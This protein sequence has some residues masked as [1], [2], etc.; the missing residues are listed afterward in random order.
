MLDHIKTTEGFHYKG[1]LIS[2]E[3]EYYKCQEC[4]GEFEDPNN[5]NDPL[6]EV[7]RKYKLKGKENYE[8]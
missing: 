3:V 7:Y 4:G 2:V 8:L 1:E 5:Q 6:E